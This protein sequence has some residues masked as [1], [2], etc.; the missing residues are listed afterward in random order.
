[1]S[2]LSKRVGRV[3]MSQ[4]SA[5]FW[6]VL[7]TMSWGLS[8]VFLKALTP[9]LHPFEILAIRFTLS[10]ALCCFIFRRRLAL[11]N[12][13]VLWRGVVLG[14][15]MFFCNLA[16]VTGVSTTDASTASFLTSTAIVIVPVA[17]AVRHRH[18]PERKIIL[19]TLGTTVGIALLSLEGGSFELSRGASLCILSAFL[20][21][22]HII[23]T[24][25]YCHGHDAILLGLIQ[26]LTMGALGWIATLLFI[27]PV[28][29]QAPQVWLF[30]SGLVLICGAFAY[31]LQPLAQSFTTPE[32]TALIFSMEPVFGA[33]FAFLFLGEV[34]SFQASCG[35]ILVLLSVLLTTV[36]RPDKK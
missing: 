15:I 22:A 14:T 31:T 5:N 16:I 24:D 34:L 17:Q 32:H 25:A 12:R 29:P 20:Y 11:L 10:G 28:F 2:I 3:G 21:A 4:R 9:Y 36:K 18:L 30:L 7:V 23:T 13:Q 19:G 26:Q 6:L 35:A 33:F 27:T 8:Y 1:M